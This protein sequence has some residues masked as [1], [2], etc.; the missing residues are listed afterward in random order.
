M[1]GEAP[2]SA[3][4]SVLQGAAHA[5]R[6]EWAEAARSYRAALER[7]PTSPDLLNGLAWA[8]LQLGQRRSAADLLER[9]LALKSDQPEISQLLAEV[10]ERR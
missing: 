5:R 1:L 3:E 8:E 10:R 2:P 7:G 6:G 9:S 4:R